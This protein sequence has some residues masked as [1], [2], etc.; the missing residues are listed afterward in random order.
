MFLFKFYKFKYICYINMKYSNN[1]LFLRKY[2]FKIKM[3]N[4]III[5]NSKYFIYL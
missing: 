4:L 1:I 5:I 3:I 2:K